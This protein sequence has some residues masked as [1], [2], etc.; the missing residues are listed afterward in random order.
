MRTHTLTHSYFALRAR[1]ATILQMDK[2][3]IVAVSHTLLH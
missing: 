2:S 1:Y 3:A